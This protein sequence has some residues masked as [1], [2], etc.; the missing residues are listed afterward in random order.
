MTDY[1]YDSIFF[2][3]LEEQ[4]AVITT[5]IQEG[6]DALWDTWNN[7]ILS[8]ADG[9]WGAVI[10]PG[11]ALTAHHLKGKLEDQI[12]RLWDQFEETVEDFWQEVEKWTGDPGDLMRM[13][14]DYHDAA[15]WIR[16]EKRVITEIMGELGESWSGV[17]FGSFTDISSKFSNALQGVDDGLSQAATGSAETALQIRSA[18]N[19][20]ISAVLNV[21]DLVL[22]AIKDGTDAGQWVTFDAGPAIKVVG[23]ILVEALRL[24]LALK[25]FIDENATVQVSMWRGLASGMEGLDAENRWPSISSGDRDYSQPGEWQP[26]SG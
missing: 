20:V 16:D 17:A 9:F 14:D 15:G 22:D 10:S 19:E 23:K 6:I 3:D 7:S 11:A 13:N 2:D 8:K 21:V 18:W 24:G 4:V 5:K 26:A 25:T 12:S 1:D